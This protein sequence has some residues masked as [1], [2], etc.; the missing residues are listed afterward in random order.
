MTSRPAPAPS[1]R[2]ISVRRE[3]PP[4]CVARRALSDGAVS[5]SLGGRDPAVE[6]MRQGLGP[7]DSIWPARRVTCPDPQAFE[8]GAGEAPHLLELAR[9]MVAP[10]P[11]MRYGRRRSPARAPRSARVARAGRGRRRASPAPAA[12]RRCFHVGHDRVAVLRAVGQRP[13][14]Y[15][16]GSA[17]RPNP[18]SSW[19]SVMPRLR[20]RG[21]RG[22]RRHRVATMTAQAIRAPPLPASVTWSSSVGMDDERAEPSASNR[23][24]GPSVRVTRSVRRRGG[25][26]RRR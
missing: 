14:M 26:G 5:A 11:V 7:R 2:R 22:H 3:K 17:N 1:A 23:V 25:R 20:S 21:R 18:A 6:D 19:S 24:A 13:R 8:A 16:D 10:W 9:S 12:P 4:V 15:R